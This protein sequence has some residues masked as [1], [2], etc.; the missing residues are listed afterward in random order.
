MGLLD[1][2]REAALSGV[3]RGRHGCSGDGTP[4]STRIPPTVEIA[5]LMLGGLTVNSAA[6]PLVLWSWN[7]HMLLSK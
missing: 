6:P 5:S 1:V 4:L 2:Y 3:R 7:F